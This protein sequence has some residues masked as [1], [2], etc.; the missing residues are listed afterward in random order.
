MF[1]WHEK[2][3]L[4]WVFWVLI[5]NIYPTLYFRNYDKYFLFVYNSL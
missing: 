5:Q 3:Y 1:K 2:A 4:P